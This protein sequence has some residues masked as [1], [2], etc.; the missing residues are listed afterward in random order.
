MERVLRFNAWVRGLVY[1]VLFGIK[2]GRAFRIGKDCV[3]SRRL[4]QA[5][6]HV[7]IGAFCQVSGHVELAD[8]VFI[9]R[10]VILRA[11]DGVI[12]IG[13]GTTVNPYSRIYGKGGVTIGSMV[14]IAPGVTIVAANKN[15]SDVNTPIKLQGVTT[16]GIVIHDDV[17]IGANAT[18]LDGVTLGEGC[19]VGAGAVV[20]RDVAA[21]SVVGGVP[22]VVI[23]ERGIPVEGL[24]DAEC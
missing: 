14:S 10:H 3:L 17:W 6:D 20:T 9:H 7:N 22:A 15:T 21:K 1:R 24:G 12:T 13:R 5:G 19:V 2:V 8:D 11:F 4:L 23:G 16:R 18:I